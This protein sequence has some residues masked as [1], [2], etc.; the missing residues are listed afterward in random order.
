MLNT[1]YDN[2]FSKKGMVQAFALFYS[3]Q[4]GCTRILGE[5]S[6]SMEPFSLYPINHLHKAVWYKLGR[7]QICNPSSGPQFSAEQA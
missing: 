7:K 3:S 4:Y 6:P 1:K 2:G 5:P